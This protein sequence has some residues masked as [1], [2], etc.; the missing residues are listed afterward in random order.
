[1]RFELEPY[2]RNVPEADL[3]ADLQRVARELD[4]DSVTYHQYDA[5]GKYSTKTVEKRFGSWNKGLSAASLAIGKRH[6]IPRE[7]LFENL[8]RLWGKFGRQPRRD[9]L[10]DESSTI[11]SG[12]Y[13]NQ[14]G[15][16]R[17]ALQAFVDYM[18]QEE[19]EAPEILSSKAQSKTPRQPN[20]R[21]RWRVMNRDRFRCCHCG[22][23]PS[24][25]PGLILHVDHI[26]PWSK[27]GP[28]VEGN[29]QTLYSDHNYGKSDELESAL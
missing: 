10:S 20:L 12:T 29:L 15:S 4:A 16:W 28:T 3:I 23:S 25:H 2:H 5:H 19:V 22:R 11:S 7:D 1:M 14:F 8:E 24:T 6:G 9:E 26:K 21:M 17:K 27:G 18:N 13:E